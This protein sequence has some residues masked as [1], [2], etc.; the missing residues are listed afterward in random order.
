MKSVLVMLF[1]LFA[2]TAF[3]HGNHPKPIATCVA[4]CTQVEVETAVSL[5]VSTLV[6]KGKVAASWNNAK[7]EK[8]EKKEFKKGEEWV[9]TLFDST[10][11]DATKQRLYVFITTDGFLNGANFTGN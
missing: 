6:T 8:V 11:K 1:S 4:V 10:E 2:A 9:A 7:V 5:A 3:G